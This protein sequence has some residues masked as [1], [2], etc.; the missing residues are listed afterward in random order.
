MIIA[1]EIL[2]VA[3][4][5]FDLNVTESKPNLRVKLITSI[6]YL[7]YRTEFSSNR[8]NFVI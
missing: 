8:W 7:R 2:L 3:D 1:N 6:V 4:Y 5:D